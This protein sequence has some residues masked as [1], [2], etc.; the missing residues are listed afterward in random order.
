MNAEA[1]YHVRSV[2]RQGIGLRPITTRESSDLTCSVTE[3]TVDEGL[4][5]TL[6]E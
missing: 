1:G 5:L 4:Y 2:E 3:P 6:I